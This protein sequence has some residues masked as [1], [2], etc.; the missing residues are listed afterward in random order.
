MN[1]GRLKAALESSMRVICSRVSVPNAGGEKLDGAPGGFLAGARTAVWP[2]PP[3]SGS[4]LYAH[5]IELRHIDLLERDFWTITIRRR[6]RMVD[7][8]MPWHGLRLKK[9][10]GLSNG[11][12]TFGTRCHYA[13]ITTLKTCSPLAAI[14]KQTYTRI[15][16]RSNKLQHKVKHLRNIVQ[17]SVPLPIPPATREMYL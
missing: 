12:L 5:V 11:P 14:S 4:R 7:E 16:P 2:R 17:E 6:G 13:L 1:N 3:H 15:I 8:R 10:L 9:W